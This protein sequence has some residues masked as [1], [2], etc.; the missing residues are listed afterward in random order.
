VRK[1]LYG[2]DLSGKP[3]NNPTIDP[4]LLDGIAALS[5]IAA[6]GLVDLT[7]KVNEMIDR[8]NLLTDALRDPV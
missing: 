3:T 2:W 7:A 6:P 8:I 4:S 5:H 1:R